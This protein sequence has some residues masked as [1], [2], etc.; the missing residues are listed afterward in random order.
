M[1][2]R[3]VLCPPMPLPSPHESVTVSLEPC[4]RPVLDQPLEGES[5]YVLGPDNGFRKACQ[6]LS[7]NPLFDTFIIVLIVISSIC[8]ALDVP[9]LDPNSQLHDILTVS[10]PLTH[11]PPPRDLF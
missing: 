10:K 11:C 2:L 8:L 3:G 5:L 6:W 4:V 1:R 9:R 7:C